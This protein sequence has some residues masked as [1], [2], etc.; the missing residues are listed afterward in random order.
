[1]KIKAGRMPSKEQQKV[2]SFLEKDIQNR[3]TNYIKELQAAINE[4]ENKEYIKKYINS[5][6]QELKEA[7]VTLAFVNQS[8][9]KATSPQEKT[10]ADLI[11]NRE[12]L[13][14]KIKSYK[15][16]RDEDLTTNLLNQKTNG[17]YREILQTIESKKHC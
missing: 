15:F 9:D 12:Q 2:I 16:I 10:V 13:E 17:L 4:P 11:F 14:S 6:Q 3:K 8:I 1:M 5:I 7:K